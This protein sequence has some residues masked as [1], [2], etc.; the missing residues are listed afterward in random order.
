VLLGLP[1]LGFL[2]LPGV[3]WAA[4]LAA[5]AAAGLSYQL[6]L[7]RRFLDAVPEKARGQAFGL[8]SAGL[9]T[10]QAVGAALV[11]VIGELHSPSLAIAVAGAAGVAV[12]L[13]LAGSLRPSRA[14][15]RHPVPEG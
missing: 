1:W 15:E 11:G 4:V 7:Q 2:L 14:E 6:G 5:L 13:S 8:L 12:A 10:G 3:A 9:M